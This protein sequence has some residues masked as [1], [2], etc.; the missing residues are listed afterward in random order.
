MARPALKAL[1]KELFKTSNWVKWIAD[2][3]LRVIL[4]L[5]AVSFLVILFAGFCV[6]FKSSYRPPQD[7]F[8]RL[9]CF[10]KTL[11]GAWPLLVIFVIPV[12]YAYFD[13]IHGVL[14]KLIAAIQKYREESTMRPAPPPPPPTASGA[15]PQALKDS[16]ACQIE[17]KP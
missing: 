15:G 13:I 16:S 2:L 10:L 6:V 3:I 8:E 1:I 17:E 14:A 12:V 4:L 7:T 11:I 9:V 5:A